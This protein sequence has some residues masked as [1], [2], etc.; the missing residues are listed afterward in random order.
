MDHHCPWIMNCV[1][2]RNHKYF[3][4]LVVYAVANCSF[5]A[6]TILESVHLS[7]VEE[8]PSTNRFLLVLG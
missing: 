6:F 4:L 7:T 3:F 8:T 1:G 5:I 2:F